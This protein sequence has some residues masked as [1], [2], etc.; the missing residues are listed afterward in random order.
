MK[1]RIK[2]KIKIG[3]LQWSQANCLGTSRRGD[4]EGE[5]IMYSWEKHEVGFNELICIYVGKNEFTNI[6]W[7]CTTLSIN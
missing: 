7:K 2:R 5:K 6:P 3:D 1:C 4:P